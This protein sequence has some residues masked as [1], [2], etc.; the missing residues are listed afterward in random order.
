MSDTA[1]Q[2]PALKKYSSPNRKTPSKRW[3]PVWESAGLLFDTSKPGCKLPRAVF[4]RHAAHGP[5][6]FQ[7]TLMDTMIRFI[8]G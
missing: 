4:D 6:A 2:I 7:Q 3:Y 8:T 5:R 1:N